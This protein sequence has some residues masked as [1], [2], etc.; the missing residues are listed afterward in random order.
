ML[1][2]W[3]KNL[4]DPQTALGGLYRCAKFRWN[5]LSIVFV[6]LSF[7]RPRPFFKRLASK[8]PFTP[9]IVFG[10]GLTPYIGGSINETPKRH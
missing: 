1:D 7:N 6:V 10:G 2:L 8:H 4:Y 9:Q 5:R 3:G